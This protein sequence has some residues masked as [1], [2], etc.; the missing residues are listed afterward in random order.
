MKRTFRIDLLSHFQVNHTVLLII[1]T[2]LPWHPQDNLITKKNK[3][4]KKTFVLFNHLHVSF[5]FWIH[6]S[7]THGKKAN[8][9]WGPTVCQGCTS[10]K[11]FICTVSKQLPNSSANSV[12]GPFYIW[13]NWGLGRFCG[14]LGATELVV[15]RTGI[16]IQARFQRS[17][18]LL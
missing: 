12:S 8:I 2:I 17:A 6:L 5:L 7:F 13:A 16:Q 3:N 11:Q 1:V 10:G 15:S 9:P 4:K 14:C 18:I